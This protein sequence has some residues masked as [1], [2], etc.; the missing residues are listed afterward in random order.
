MPFAIELGLDGESAGPV[1]SLW[2]RL[3][4][5][6]IRYMADS[7]AEPHVSVAI[8]DDLRVERAAIEVAALVTQ[9]APVP[10][11]F[12]QVRTFGAEV[13][14]LAVAPSARLVDLHARVQARIGPL[15]DGAW[16][17]YAPG[18]WIPH[19]TLAMD[20]DTGT[21]ATALALATGFALPLTGRLDRMAI[22]EF[23]PVRERFC[24]P[25][26]GR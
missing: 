23:R 1:R 16:E 26:T 20:L 17:H 14:Y 6:G 21:A 7:G 8:W 10:L 13:V 2:R 19:C 15:G 3:A 25:L 18:A 12:T 9:T 5:A 11:S 4:E 22:V 24:Q